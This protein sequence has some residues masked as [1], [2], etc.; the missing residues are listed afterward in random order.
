[1]KPYVI[2]TRI[3]AIIA[4]VEFSVMVLLSYLD[5]TEGVFE[6]MVDAV[7]LAFISAPFLYIWVIRTVAKNLKA[8]AQREKVLLEAYAENIVKSVPSGLVVLS[9]DLRILST[10]PAFNRMFNLKE[11]DLTFKVIFDVLPLERLKEAV[12]GILSG[13]KPFRNMIFEL[14]EEKRKRFLEISAREIHST[15]KEDKVLLIINDVTEH[16]EAVEKIHRGFQL[17][18][19]L[20]KLLRISLEDIS[21]DNMLERII[22]EIVSLPWLSIESKGGIWLVEDEPDVLVLRAQR[23]LPLSL[24]KACHH[25][26]FGKCLCGMCAKEKTL[27]FTSHI[28]ERHERSYEDM[29]P[30]GHYCVPIKYSDRVFGIINLYV[31]DGHRFDATE[32]EFISSI[33]DILAGIIRRKKAEEALQASEAKFH[34]I[35]SSAQ[36]AIIMMDSEGK[37]SYWNPAS[38]RMFGY[39]SEEA[40][41]KELHQ[42]IVPPVHLKGFKA[43]FEKFKNTGHGA[44]LGKTL[45]LS[46]VR[47]DGTVFPVE[48]SISAEKLDGKWNSIGIVRDITERKR[49]EEMIVHMAYHDHLTGLPNRLLLID[50]LNQVVARGRRK[51]FYAAILFLDLDRFKV[52]NDTL[53]H[54]VGDKLLKA[55]AERLKNCLR[56]GDTVARLGGD[57]FTVLLQEIN[58]PQDVTKVVEKI[59]SA[60]ETPFVIDGHELF[61]TTSIGIS[62]FPND[63]EDTDTLLKNADIA[64]YRAKDEGRNNYQ[65]YTPSM[66]ASAGER[67]KLENRLRKAIEKN[68]FFLLF[69]PQVDV[70]TGEIIGIE[71]LLRWKES[72]ERLI[73]PKEFIPLAE[74]TGLIVPIGE[75]VL[76]RACEQNRIWQEK[77]LKPV[78]IAVN[79]SMRQFKQRDFV[80]TLSRIL[81]DT[82]LSAGYLELEFTESIIMDNAESTIETMQA[83]KAMGIRLA[84]DDFGTGYSS[85]EYLR[86]IPIDILKI[87][88]AFVRNITVN[89]DDAT[90]VIAIIRMAHSL[91]LEVIAEGVETEEQ[92]KFLRNLQCDKIQGFIISRPIPPEEM[93]EF[94][95]KE[96]VFIKTVSGEEVAKGYQKNQNLYI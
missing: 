79:I 71:A 15:D 49:S 52:I 43:G 21:L 33:A 39:T 83:L 2:F 61:I 1:M 53:G 35:S 51:K 59:F 18:T 34:K 92:L 17:Q 74:D 25:I 54:P 50:R 76:R 8:E 85:L 4:I 41:G 7:L 46:A 94:L 11:E 10:N 16:R 63:G 30:H 82:K 14:D 48:V 70:K 55:V 58:R 28:D 38:E 81:K 47:K 57:E 60:F 22:E 93:E 90:I 23:G 69:Q 19:I 26:P 77:G 89:Q 73:S 56:E 24:Q 88:Q 31:K 67:L 27:K 6:F 42:L 68:E 13:D 96:K 9:K 40:V 45:E 65:L 72:G 36:D 91:K 64:M 75:W 95:K 29:T 62:I 12:K 32:A 5:L 78:K 66:N 44:V 20:N 80:D 84:I 86:R 3:L 37:I 87:A